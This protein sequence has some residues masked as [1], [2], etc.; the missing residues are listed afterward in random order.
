[1]RA[2]L[3][4]YL[5]HSIPVWNIGRSSPATTRHCRDYDHRYLK[6]TFVAPVN[7]KM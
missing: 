3:V 4:L 5:H 1:M 2:K 6:A 7:V